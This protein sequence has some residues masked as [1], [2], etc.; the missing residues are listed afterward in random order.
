VTK[1]W[2]VL[3]AVAVVGTMTG[4]LV[5]AEGE[6]A[7]KGERQRGEGKPRGEWFKTMDTDS[8]GTVSVSEFTVAHEKRQA[9][10]KARLGDKWD[11]DRAAKAPSAEDRFKKIDADG[12]G[13]LTKEEM[14][15]ARE[16]RQRR[17]QKDGEEPKKDGENKGAE[18]KSE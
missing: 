8:N 2:K 10:M 4:A 17:A 5:R 11:A 9:E 15:K 13:E 16:N 14:Q 18:D 7:A 12:N 1:S 6:D 3:L